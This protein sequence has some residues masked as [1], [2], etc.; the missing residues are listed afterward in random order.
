MAPVLRLPDRQQH[1]L[2]TAA[3]AAATSAALLVPLR[4]WAAPSPPQRRPRGDVAAAAAAPGGEATAPQMRRAGVAAAA[5]ACLGALGLRARRARALVSVVQP[6]TSFLAAADSAMGGDEDREAEYASYM[7]RKMQGQKLPG[8]VRE[9]KG[10]LFEKLWKNIP[11]IKGTFPVLV[12]IG[13]GTSYNSSNYLD[14]GAPKHI[15]IVGIDPNENMAEYAKRAAASQGLFPRHSLRVV[16]GVA[17]ALPLADGVADAVVSTFC[18][19]AVA[20]PARAVSEVRRVLK[21][22]GQLLFLEHVLDHRPGVAEEQR[23]VHILADGGR[24]HVDR[25]TLAAV[26]AGGFKN[27]EAKYF[28]I[29]QTMTGAVVAGLATA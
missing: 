12:E 24:C 1:G 6:P 23:R 2:A 13:I 11:Q 3:A 19:C 16:R 15:D 5:G 26:K 21:P 28:E 22:G 17:E 25:D 8:K 10:V 4:A 14:A 18:L 7:Y 9:Q 27:V 29:N 20:D